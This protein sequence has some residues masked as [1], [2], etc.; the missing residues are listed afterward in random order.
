MVTCPADRCSKPISLMDRAAHR[1]GKSLRIDQA[2]AVTSTAEDYL[3][4]IRDFRAQNVDR[5]ASYRQRGQGEFTHNLER[6]CS[7]HND[8]AFR[9][10]KTR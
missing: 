6:G 8:L 7:I 9:A 4:C 5:L 2:L 10:V 1:D 3:D